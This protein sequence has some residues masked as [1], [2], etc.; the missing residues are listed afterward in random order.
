LIQH[1]KDRPGHDRRYAIDA[2]KLRSL[3]WQP[4]VKWEDGIAETVAWY[5]ENEVWWRRIK[6]GEFKSYYEK[7]YAGLGAKL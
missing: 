4:H 5:R 2:A 7:Q 3:G 1:I 6:S